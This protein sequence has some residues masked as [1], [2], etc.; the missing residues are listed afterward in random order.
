MDGERNELELKEPTAFHLVPEPVWT[1]RPPGGYRPERFAAD[2]FIH[3]SHGE[4]E[5]LAVANR[6]YAADPRPYLVL[7]V[8]LAGAGS[9]VRY[10]DPD[11]R[12]PHVYGPLAPEGVVA[13]RRALRSAAGSFFGI[14]AEPA[15]GDGA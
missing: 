4:A 5:V 9:P 10:D 8:D 1:A 11:R 3:L 2:G 12:Y 13:V 6:Y 15:D 7:T 14:A